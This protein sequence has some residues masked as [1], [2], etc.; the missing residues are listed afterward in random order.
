MKMSKRMWC[1]MAVCVAVAGNAPALADVTY[2]KC[3]MQTALHRAWLGD[4]E[5]THAEDT[6]TKYF[7]IDR[8]AKT[9]EVYIGMGDQLVPICSSKNTACVAKW[10]QTSS[11][12]S[13]DATQAPDDPV[14]PHIDFRRAFEL[15]DDGHK[16]HFLIAD[17]GE[18][19]TGKA[20]MSWTYDGNCEPSGS[21][22]PRFIP[23]GHNP[24]YTNAL[25]MPVSQQ[26]EAAAWANR[27]GNTMAGLSYGGQ[28][29][30]YYGGRV[31]FHMWIFSDGLVYT[32]DGYDM[33]AEHTPRHMYVGKDAKGVY[34][35]CA[36]PIPA[37]GMK[38]CESWPTVKLG[39]DW[40]EQDP[41]APAHFT[42]LPGRQ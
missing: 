29:V 9:V 21:K 8:A 25:V 31:W 10:S 17:F 3:S 23:E 37:Q 38:G 1:G 13:I 24:N 11:A 22:P 35:A 15:S 19:K 2:L 16:A 27:K 18:S 33:S 30:P 14:P 40:V 4:T 20:N 26:E 7:A 32:G 12:V 41:F 34:W 5:W 6:I 39:E 28:T 36:K 42:L